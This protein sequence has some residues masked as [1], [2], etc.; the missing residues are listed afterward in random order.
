MSIRVDFPHPEGAESTINSG[1]TV[2][3]TLR[4]S[5]ERTRPGGRRRGRRHDRLRHHDRRGLHDRR[6]R[7]DHGGG[8]LNDDRRGLHVRRLVDH[9]RLL[10]D[11]RRRGRRRRRR[12][13]RSQDRG[14]QAGRNAARDTSRNGIAAMMMMLHTHINLVKSKAL[15]SE[16]VLI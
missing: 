15:S 6:L 1:F 3:A 4:P 12:R 8:L 10:H 16:K 7:D 13:R 14:R 11:H 9:H 5:P 2:M